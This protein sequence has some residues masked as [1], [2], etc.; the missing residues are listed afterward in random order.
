M[1]KKTWASLLIAVVVVV[2]VVAGVYALSRNQAKDQAAVFDPL[3]ATYTIEGQPITLVNGTAETNATTMFGEPV[4]GDLNGDG[5]A[6]AAV[7]LVQNPGGSGTFYYVAA[8]INTAHGAQGT[9][10]ILLG[11][12]VAP[13]NIQIENG[14]VIAN[15]ADRKPGEPMTTMPSVGV[16]M[17]LIYDGSKLATSSRGIMK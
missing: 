9:N 7:M 17:Y 2:A 3:N 4:S 14:Q 6:D 5:K 16:S 8:A 13:Q 15:Y 1:N 12:R 10:A 11:D